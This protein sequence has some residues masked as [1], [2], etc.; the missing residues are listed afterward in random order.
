MDIV[1]LLRPLMF[2]D[3]SPPVP[4]VPH[5]EMLPGVGPKVG[6][7]M[8]VAHPREAFTPD[9]LEEGARSERT[10]LGNHPTF[11]VVLHFFTLAGKSGTREPA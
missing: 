2:G 6:L 11:T 4:F 5:F 9:H 1:L 10:V 3:R 8:T 7:G